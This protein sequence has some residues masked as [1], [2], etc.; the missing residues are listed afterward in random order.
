MRKNRKWIPDYQSL[1]HCWK[2]TKR[3]RRIKTWQYLKEEPQLHV[4]E[5]AVRTRSF[6]C[7]VWLSARTAERSTC[8][9][10]YARSAAARNDEMAQ[11]NKKHE[12][13]QTIML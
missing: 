1:S 12:Q 13:R 8:H 2:V 7:L 5:N 4:K 6:Q 9:T 3:I 10:A 11:P